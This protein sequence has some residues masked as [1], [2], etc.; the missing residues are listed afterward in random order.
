MAQAKI[1]LFNTLTR[2]KEEFVPLESGKVGIYCCGPTVYHYAHI[3]NLR[4]YL[5][6]DLLRRTFARAKYDVH[7]VMNITDV[8]HL[9]S[10]A[11]DGEDKMALA[12]KRENKSPWDIAKF[13]EEAFFTDCAQLEILKPHTVCRATDHIAE[14]IAMVQTLMDKGFAYRGA[15][16]QPNIYF[17][18]A[19]FAAYRDFARLVQ[20]PGAQARVDEDASKRNP[21]D[22]VLWFTLEGSKYPNQIMQWDSPWGRGFPGWHIE[23]SAMATKYLGAR[24]DIHC[25]GIDHIP[26]HH[27]NEIAQSECCSGHKWVNYWLHNEFLLLDAGKMSKSSGDFLT[28]QKLVKDGYR[29]AHYRYLCLT[30]HYRGQLKFSYDSLNDARVAYN[31]LCHKVEDIKQ[32][33]I[34]PSASS[35]AKEVV[36]RIDAAMRDDLNSPEA[37]AI[38]WDSV[39]G[40]LNP[41]EI[42]FVLDAADSALG[43]SG[44]QLDRPA[45]TAEQSD[46]LYKR[47]AARRAKDWILSDQLRDLLRTKNIVVKD[48]PEGSSWYY[49]DYIFAPETGK[50]TVEH[51][52]AKLK[53]KKDETQ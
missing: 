7:H 19:K 50:F 48:R 24:I 20:D 14:M 51:G 29:P 43:L 39:R 37:L 34:V 38:L 23:C 16:A 53:I 21:G 10:D 18:T 44:L 22:F 33:K 13:Y 52:D 1:Q 41:A 5:F 30:A 45:L 31:T 9:Q 32:M 47:D 3:G 15:G 28:L 26:V 27:T 36:E 8:G 4:S 12:Q 2:S 11:D 42:L 25:G 17:D 35:Q 6:E 40:N 46:L 49:S